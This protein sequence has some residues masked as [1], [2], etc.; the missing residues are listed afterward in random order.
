MTTS[1]SSGSGSGVSMIRKLFSLSNKAAFIIFPFDDHTESTGPE[2]IEQRYLISFDK[3]FQEDILNS[4][5]NIHFYCMGQLSLNVIN[6]PLPG[7]K[8][9]VSGLWHAWHD[10]RPCQTLPGKASAS[11]RKD[12]IHPQA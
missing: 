12:A 8:P 5:F 11:L 2:C 7:L 6:E 3:T 10:L 4:K 9:G 1:F